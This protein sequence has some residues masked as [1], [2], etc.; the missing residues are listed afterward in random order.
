[1]AFPA[2]S[3]GGRASR[4]PR[5][6][7]SILDFGPFARLPEDAQRRL[8]AAGRLV[9]FPAGATLILEGDPPE[10]AFVV[11]S[12]R[13]RIQAGPD[14][15]TLATLAA[16]ALVGEIAAI[17]RTP[18]TASVL[19]TGPVRGLRLPAAAL[20][21]AAAGDP[22]F[23][24]E[25]HAFSEARAVRTF[26]QRDSPFNELPAAA[27]AEL[28]ARLELVRFEAGDILLR[29]GERGDDAYLLRSGEVEIERG[30]PPRPLGVSTAGAIVGEVSAL[31]GE[32]RNATVRART[33]VDAFRISGEHV[34]PIV[35]RYKATVERLESAMR[36][37]HAPRRMGRPRMEI[38]PDDPASV[39]IYDDSSGAYLR[40]GREAL[41]IYENLDGE[42]SM[43]DLAM[44]H[45]QRT[46]ALDPQGVFETVATFQAAGLVTAPRIASDEPN[47]RLL[48]VA[49]A[50]L[51]PRLELASADRLAAALHRSLG[52][53]FT[54]PGGIAALVVGTV[55]TILFFRL[56]RLASPTDFG[57]AG[58]AVAFFGLFLAGIGHEAAHAIATKAEGRRVGRAGIGI[59]WFTPVI[60]VDTSDAWLIDR[61]RRAL[62]SAAG[63]LFNYAAAGAFGIA[64]AL[65]ADRTQDLMLWLAAV[66]LASVVFN[67]S[68][69][70]EFD[71]YYALSDLANVNALR[72]KALRFV[73]RDLVRQP[74]RPRT[75]TEAGFLAYAVAALVYVLVVSV[76]VLLGVPGIVDGVLAGRVEGALRAAIGSVVALIFTAMLV[77]PFL[78]EVAAARSEAG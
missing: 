12:G 48:R 68:P 76:V 20:R 25:L 51:A 2:P 78:G 21:A 77:G 50:I 49:D 66:N 8:A 40:L 39:I 34:R 63:P 45:F 53:A 33:A 36:S 61:R 31:T 26:L 24:D 11:L 69:L 27:A 1:M 29:E 4:Y 71:G 38:S 7:P 22:G 6:V 10:D 17:E 32:P 19:A 52:W 65:T 67:L 70:L 41:A 75:R 64:A 28:A 13:V 16:P 37:R 44:L 42:R 15:K 9:D 30:D 14:R 35:K 72:R 59:L 46:G 56:F 57:L 18:R 74:R 23:A 3:P 60:Y 5:G 55:G 73:F 62:V 43:R 47:G 58:I 54:R